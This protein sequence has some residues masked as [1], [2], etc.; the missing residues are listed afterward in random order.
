MRSTSKNS[1]SYCHCNIMKRRMLCVCESVRSF[2]EDWRLIPHN[3]PTFQT[4]LVLCVHSVYQ[5]KCHNLNQ[6]FFLFFIFCVQLHIRSFPS[7]LNINENDKWLTGIF[8]VGFGPLLTTPPIPPPT[9]VH[10]TRTFTQT[11]SKTNEHPPSA[12]W[13]KIFTLASEILLLKVQSKR[14]TQIANTSYF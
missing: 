7:L 4:R 11:G 10:T 13:E 14:C 1:S 12:K 6:G 9:M 8:K 5:W 2:R 3:L